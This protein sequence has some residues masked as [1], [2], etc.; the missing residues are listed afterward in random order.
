MTFSKQT[1]DHVTPYSE[2]K[3]I[4]LKSHPFRG[5]G[6]PARSGPRQ[7]IQVYTL[8]LVLFF[9]AP[10][11]LPVPLML[12]KRVEHALDSELCACWSLCLEYPHPPPQIFTE[13]PLPLPLQLRSTVPSSE[14]PAVG[15]SEKQ[16]LSSITSLPSTLLSLWDLSTPWNV[17]I[18]FVF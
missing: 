10:D 8:P 12:F 5:L 2:L 9:S 13:F 16:H 15:T 6:G 1:S 17:I 14:K 3:A 18:F 4:S 7:C 11:Y